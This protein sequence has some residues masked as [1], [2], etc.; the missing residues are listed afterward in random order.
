MHCGACPENQVWRRRAVSAPR[1]PHEHHRKRARRFGVVYEPISALKVFARD[2]W[3]CGIC[4]KR[5]NPHHRWP[6]QMC[7]SL[8][9]IVPMSLGGGHLYV[10]VQCS[11]WLCNSRKS[12][13]GVGDQLA[14]IG[15]VG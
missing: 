12:N 13:R 15:G 2:G 10:N 8:D 6:N 9:H 1:R 14:L 11:H 4:R 5:V 7:A 3:V